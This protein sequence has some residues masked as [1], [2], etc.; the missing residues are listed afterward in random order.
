M[1]GHNRML[2]AGLIQIV[3]IRMTLFRN[4]GVVIVGTLYQSPA[5]VLS[6]L[7]LS[8][9][10]RS[11]ILTTGPSGGQFRLTLNK[12]I[13]LSPGKWPCPSTKPGNMVLPRRS[14]ILLTFAASR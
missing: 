9:L 2:R 3:T 8:S 13:W 4:H 5:L 6:A 1:H 12:S 10:T 14:T 7:T 11:S